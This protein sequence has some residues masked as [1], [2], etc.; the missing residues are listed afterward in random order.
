MIREALMQLDLFITQK[1]REY[2]TPAMTVGVTD[3][4]QT[5][6]LATEGVANVDAR[7]PTIGSTLFQIGSIGKIFT[8]IAILQLYEDGLLD[9]HAPVQ[10]CLPWFEVQTVYDDPITVHHL[11]THTAGIIS[12]MDFTGEHA[13]EVYSLRDTETSTPPGTY[14]HYSNVGYKALTLILERLTGVSYGEV[15]QKR[16]LTP[17]GMVSTLPVITHESRKRMA[18]GYTHL[19]DD[20]PAPPSLPLVPAPWME[21]G[22]GDGSIVSNA[23]DMCTFM[24]M[25]MHDGVTASGEALISEYAFAR[26]V[27]PYIDAFGVHQYGYGMIVST[28]DDTVHYGHGGSMPGFSSTLLVDEANGI[29]AV[30]LANHSHADTFSIINTALRVVRAT[31]SHQPVKVPRVRESTY[32]EN[33]DDYA[34]TYRDGAREL[35]FTTSRHHL[36]L[37]LPQGRL[38]LSRISGDRFMGDHP[39]LGY[40][41]FV[42]G[43][44]ASGTVVEVFHGADW[45][46]T[47]DY[48]GETV[49]DVPPL[50]MAYTGR[51]RAHNLWNPTYKVVI[52]KGVLMLLQASGAGDQ[53]VPLDDGTFRIGDDPRSPERATFDTITDGQALR[54]TISC[55]PYYRFF[56]L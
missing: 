39:T 11:L 21:Y 54:V 5:F 29:G 37:S 32:V 6:F 3:H 51:Y 28:F 13:Y 55:A 45:F 52:R 9:I 23:Q 19:Y 26:M 7:Q 36:F 38:I 4:E 42:F 49:F 47:E 18:I 20:R 56:T 25:L 15:I 14:F 27:T 41:A 12:G 43:R 31:R 35:I 16:I 30:A 40:D 1:M 33:G 8:A 46:V 2:N 10:T 22:Y 53:L 34:G 48:V 44:D 50:W 24:R 17:L